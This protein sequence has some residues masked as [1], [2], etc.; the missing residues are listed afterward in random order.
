[1]YEVRIDNSKQKSDRRKNKKTRFKFIVAKY[2]LIN[3]TG[4]KNAYRDE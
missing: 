3:H 4:A 2:R 1:M